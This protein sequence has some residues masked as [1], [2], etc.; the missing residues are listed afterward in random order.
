VIV[1][2]DLAP[3]LRLRRKAVRDHQDAHQTARQ[4]TGV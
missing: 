1:G 3:T 2:V 4:R